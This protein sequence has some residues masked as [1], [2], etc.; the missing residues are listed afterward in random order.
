MSWAVE[1][2]SCSV[3]L[4]APVPACT[5]WQPSRHRCLCRHQQQRGAS[6]ANSVS[7]MPFTQS[8]SQ[9]TEAGGPETLGDFSQDF[10]LG[11]GNF[12]FKSQV[13]LVHCS[14]SLMMSRM[15]WP[16]GYL[17][18]CRPCLRASSTAAAD[19]SPTVQDQSSLAVQ[20]TEPVHEQS[21]F[22]QQQYP[23]SQT[24]VRMHYGCPFK[25]LL[26]QLTNLAF[27]LSSAHI[28]GLKIWN[29]LSCGS[30]H[31]N[32]IEAACTFVLQT[33]DAR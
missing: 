16:G 8:G 28:C 21:F 5:G 1:C 13:G 17:E 29:S 12:D 14:S 33:Q 30:W 20:D 27:P 4:S 24:Q 9:F 3:M 26:W 10:S 31:V 19:S 2:W 22:T 25:R 23:A 6:R 18:A 15:C 32:Y 7:N 11:G